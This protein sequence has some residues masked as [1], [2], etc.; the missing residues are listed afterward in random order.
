SSQVIPSLLTLL[1][2][3]SAR[4]TKNPR[5]HRAAHIEGYTALFQVADRPRQQAQQWL[6]WLQIILNM[7]CE[8]TKKNAKKAGR[9]CLVDE[10]GRRCSGT[11][12]TPSWPS[13]SCALMIEIATSSSVS[14]RFVACCL[15][16]S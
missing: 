5:M 15:I 11:S 10:L 8:S 7:P 12:R 14:R 16:S 4:K 6:A 3:L 2:R 13:V 1:V 9:Y